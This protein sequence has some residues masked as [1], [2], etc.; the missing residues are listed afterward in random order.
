MT[1]RARLRLVALTACVAGAALLFGG[2][3]GLTR[4]QVLPG[5]V[6]YLASGGLGGLALVAVGITWLLSAESQSEQD[7]L[8]RVERAIRARAAAE[9]SAR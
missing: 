4:A 7:R 8:A 2:L 1:G 3:A 6:P 5:Q 9:E